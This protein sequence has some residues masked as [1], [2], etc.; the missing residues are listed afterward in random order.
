MGSDLNAETNDFSAKQVTVMKQNNSKILARLKFNEEII[1]FKIQARILI[2]SAG[3]GLYIFCTRS[4]TK[5]ESLQ[6]NSVFQT[7][8]SM[9]PGTDQNVDMFRIV[10]SDPAQEG[11]LSIFSCKCTLFLNLIGPP[12]DEHP[13]MCKENAPGQ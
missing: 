6:C 4:L 11:R 5:L 12:V 2:I 8:M 7:Y 13:T 1:Y 3:G 10:Y 9:V